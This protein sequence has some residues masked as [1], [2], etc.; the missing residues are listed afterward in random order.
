MEELPPQA[1][2]AYAAALAPDTDLA[3]ALIVPT[4]PTRLAPGECATITAVVP[5]ML[6]VSS[7]ALLWRGLDAGAW[8]AVPLALAG[9]RTYVY[10]FCMPPGGGPI[11]YKLQATFA[12][13]PAPVVVTAPPAGGATTYVI[14]Q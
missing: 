4:R 2:A 9:R 13:S 10:D 12:A 14:S 3:A 6:E 8:Q 11:E 5:G 1:E 7:V